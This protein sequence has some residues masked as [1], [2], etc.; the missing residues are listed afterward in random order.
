VKCCRSLGNENYLLISYNSQLLQEVCFSSPTAIKYLGEEAAVS[1][2][3][4]HSDIQAA[5]NVFDLLVGQVIV[6]GN[7]CT[8]TVPHVLTIELTSNY[9]GTDDG[10]LYDWKT[11][12]RVK[13][14]GINDVK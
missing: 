1:L 7:S 13:V 6:D 9:P 4:R 14:M 8:L 2:Q 12:A 10:S 3:A 5:S 11:V